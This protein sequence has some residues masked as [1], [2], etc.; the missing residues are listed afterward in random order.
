MAGEM[1]EKT[2]IE[3]AEEVDTTDNILVMEELHKVADTVLETLKTEADS[4]RHH[5]EIGHKVSILDLAVWV[6]KTELSS[7]RM[8]CKDLHN[9]C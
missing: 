7:P 2:E 6:E 5:P 1:V 8:D 4:P 3:V 9:S